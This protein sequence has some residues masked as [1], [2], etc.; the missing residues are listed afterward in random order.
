MSR[1]SNAVSQIKIYNKCYHCD[2]YNEDDMHCT[3]EDVNCDDA[4]AD[5]IRNEI[6]DEVIEMVKSRSDDDKL[7]N[8]YYVELITDMKR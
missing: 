7:M 8:E 4:I 1:L 3:A 6:L 2:Y 5:Q